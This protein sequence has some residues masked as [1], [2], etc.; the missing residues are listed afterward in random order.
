VSLVGAINNREI[1]GKPIQVAVVDDDASLCRAVSRLLSAAGIGCRTYDSGEAFLREQSQA[2]HNCLLLDIQLG[3]MSG[4]DLQRE[5]ALAGRNIPIIFITAYD[6]PET[7][8]E[9]QRLGCAAYLRKTD[10]G[11]AV[12]QAIRTAVKAGELQPA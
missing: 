7:R 4:F 6:E 2:E 5:L 1:C 3:G 8:E 10:S 11:Q 12:I 9:A